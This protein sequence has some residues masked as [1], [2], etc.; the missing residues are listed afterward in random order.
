MSLIK[1]GFQKLTADQLRKTIR[2]NYHQSGHA[3]L[4][5][6]ERIEGGPQRCSLPKKIQRKIGLLPPVQHGN[7]TTPDRPSPDPTPATG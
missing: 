2:R 6:A 4:E 1:R 3:S 5:W 7:D